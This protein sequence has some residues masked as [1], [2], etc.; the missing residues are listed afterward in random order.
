VKLL[1]I[2]SRSRCWSTIFFTLLQAQVSTDDARIGRR[3]HPLLVMQDHQ[4]LSRPRSNTSIFPHLPYHKT[5]I[6]FGVIVNGA[7]CVCVCSIDSKWWELVFGFTLHNYGQCRCLKSMNNLKLLHMPTPWKSKM[8]LGSYMCKLRMHF[9][10]YVGASRWC[11]KCNTPPS[12]H[13]HLL[14][15]I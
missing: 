15:I 5:P 2:I 11:W 12:I 4:Y 10:V 3:D 6:G 1:G 7:R 14:L 9:Q 13:G 8:A